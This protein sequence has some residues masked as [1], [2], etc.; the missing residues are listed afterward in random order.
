[1]KYYTANGDNFTYNYSNRENFADT[2]ED[3]MK[4]T[5]DLYVDGTFSTSQICFDGTCLTQTS[6][7]QLMN[8]AGIGLPLNA[9]EL[10]VKTAEK[11]L[12]DAIKIVQSKEA[13]LYV[14]SVEITYLTNALTTA[15]NDVT[16]TQTEATD[17]PTTATI[18]AAANAVEIATT[19][20][21]SKNNSVASHDV[22]QKELNESNVHK[23]NMKTELVAAK[24]ALSDAQEQS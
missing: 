8:L 17:N 10:A 22:L 11:N 14:S 12:N 5:G 3:S 7:K 2:T 23:D 15:N 20:L 19:A 4:I 1:M 16:I 18:T 13:L 9:L 24:K 6:L 21:E